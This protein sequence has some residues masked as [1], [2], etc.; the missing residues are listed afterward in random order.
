MIRRP[1][2]IQL[3]YAFCNFGLIF[4]WIMLDYIA[5]LQKGY[6]IVREFR[7]AIFEVKTTEISPTSSFSIIKISLVFWMV[8]NEVTH[9]DLQVRFEGQIFFF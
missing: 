7:S 6:L 9:F 5:F 3:P 1:Y 8:S 2:F 4:I